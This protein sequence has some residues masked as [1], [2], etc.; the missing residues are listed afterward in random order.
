VIL[1]DDNNGVPAANPAVA[2]VGLAVD[3]D[4]GESTKLRLLVS[5]S[6]CDPQHGYLVP[7]GD[8][9][10]IAE[11]ADSNGAL[12]TPHSGALPVVLIK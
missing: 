11:I 7:P 2:D 6:S 9:Q 4:P 12:M 10:L 3:L 1:D 8:Y 5:S